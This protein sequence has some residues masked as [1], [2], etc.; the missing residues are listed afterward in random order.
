MTEK[1][2][3]EIYQR[4]DALLEGHF[5]LSS[6][7]HSD[8][9]LQSALVMQY[10]FIAEKVV[11][12]LVEKLYDKKFTT[13]VSP[14]VGGIRFGYEVARQ[15]KKKTVFTER[16]DGVFTFRRGFSL[17]Q[18]EKVLVAEDIVTTGK[19]TRE[20]MEAI[21]KAGGE[22]IG[23][24]TLID[25]SG[26]KAEFDVPFYPLVCLEVKTYTPED[27]PM[28]KAGSKPYKPGTRVFKDDK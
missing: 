27:C 7:L 4:H 26:G 2:I 21:R 15:L 6:G 11:A 14:A 8:K 28:C 18:G 3:L 12:E 19:S 10:P 20:C 9:F 13:V 5:L 23:I 22:V 17:E 1:E 24:T 16:V 25:R